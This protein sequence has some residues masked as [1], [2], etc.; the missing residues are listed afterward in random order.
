MLELH[1]SQP[2][3][4]KVEKVLFLFSV[5][6]S[7]PDRE[8]KEKFLSGYDPLYRAGRIF[9]GWGGKH[10]QNCEQACALPATNRTL[11][12]IPLSMANPN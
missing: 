5:L 2:L 6:L 1:I 3:L 8:L 10:P 4:R 9:R 12:V 11:G 7:L